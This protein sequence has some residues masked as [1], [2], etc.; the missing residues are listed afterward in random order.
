MHPH[1]TSNRTFVPYWR[2]CCEASWCHSHGADT[3]RIWRQLYGCAWRPAPRPALMVSAGLIISLI[4]SVFQYGCILQ[5]KMTSCLMGESMIILRLT[6]CSPN[7]ARSH[8]KSLRNAWASQSICHA[9]RQ[10]RFPPYVFSTLDAICRALDCQPGD[11]LEYIPDDEAD[12]LF[13][14]KD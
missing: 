4:A 8:P 12:S 11:V 14:L 6:A 10:A 5:N 1:T 7:D 9:L 13:G 2:R 3:L